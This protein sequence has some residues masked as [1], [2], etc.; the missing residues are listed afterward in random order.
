MGCRGNIWRWTYMS[1]YSPMINQFD[2]RATDTPWLPICTTVSQMILYKSIFSTI[3]CMD[4]INVFNSEQTEESSSFTLKRNNPGHNH[5]YAMQG[6]TV[7]WN[8]YQRNCSEITESQILNLKRKPNEASVL[9]GW[10]AG[11]NLKVN[12]TVSTIIFIS[13]FAVVTGLK[14]WLRYPSFK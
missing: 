8:Q 3:W 12:K 6:V 5:V 10:K 13:G 9:E 11:G 7:T 4:K 2:N 1:R 14:S